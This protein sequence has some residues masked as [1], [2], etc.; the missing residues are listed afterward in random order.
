MTDHMTAKQF[1]EL[2]KPEKHGRIPR[3]SKLA[4]TVDGIVFDSGAEAKRYVTL[5]MMQSG[6]LISNLELQPKFDCHANGICIGAYFG[7]FQYQSRTGEIIIE[8]VKSS[9]TAKDAL[10]RWKKKHVEAEYGIRIRE[11]V[12]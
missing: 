11:C 4:R 3:A 6:G 8:D 2:N 7:D 1:Q 10:Y 5:R 9:H 12:K